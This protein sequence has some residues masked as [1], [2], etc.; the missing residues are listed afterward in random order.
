M[1]KIK[2]EFTVLSL[3][4]I[5][6]AVAINFIAGSLAFTLK[7][8]IY[9]DMIGTFIVSF[10]GGPYIGALTGVLSISLNSLT[11]PLLFPYV[12]VAG[13]LGFLVG[14]FT[15]WGWFSSSLRTAITSLLIAMIAAAMSVAITVT[16]FGGFTASGI[17]GMKAALMAMGLP[18][19]PAQIIG[20]SIAEVPDKLISLLITYS[21]VSNISARYVI[22]YPNGALFVRKDRAT[23]RILNVPAPGMQLPEETSPLPSLSS[24]FS[25]HPQNASKSLPKLNHQ[26]PKESMET[27]LDKM[28][29]SDILER[30]QPSK[31]GLEALHPLTWCYFTILLV[32]TSLLYDWRAVLPVVLFCLLLGF[33]I[34]DRA[35]FFK[36]WLKTAVFLAIVIAFFQ[37]LVIRT[38]DTA[39]QWGFIRLTTDGIARAQAFGLRVLGGFTPIILAIK[40]VESN[41]LLLAMEQKGFSP[42]ASYV[43]LS[44]INMIP[45]MGRRLRVITDAQKSRAIETEGS[46]WT[47]S[48]AFIPLI[49]PV[50]L[51]SIVSIEE[52]AMTLDVRG[53]QA[54]GKKTSLKAIKDSYSQLWLRR[55]F[56]IL[57][58]LTIVG[59]VIY[60]LH[61]A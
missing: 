6:I 46:V 13:V 59:R 37:L 11:D 3:L 31:K 16:F 55:L 28:S 53:F 7:L 36:T 43:V 33:L 10:L 23:D 8:P 24:L 39:W 35:G 48:R 21:I 58:I 22:K 14:H 50:I 26:N 40:V 4:L 54:N 19:W 5:P 42:I 51:S 57:I 20:S 17:S 30:I 1:S 38:G 61:S 44:S 25:I 34:K 56:V 15:R 45:E 18:F 60:A 52:K 27:Q 9:M 12:L 29:D 41:D 2:Q 49:S 47:R 32:I